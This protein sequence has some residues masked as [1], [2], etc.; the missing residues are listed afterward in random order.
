MNRP[1]MTYK[2]IF[3]LLSILLILA[4]APRKEKV[5]LNIDTPYNY[6]WDSIKWDS[7]AKNVEF[8]EI[9]DRNKYSKRINYPVIRIGQSGEYLVNRDFLLPVIDYKENI[10]NVELKD[11]GKYKLL[12]LQEIELPFKGLTV[13]NMTFDNGSYPL[14]ESAYLSI[15]G[16]LSDRTKKCVLSSFHLKTF[17]TEW[18][19][20]TGDIMLNRGV[21]KLLF[22]K[23]IESVFTDTLEFINNNSLMIGNLEGSVTNRGTK[24]NK[25]FTFRF[26]NR[27][28][29]YLKE[30][31]FNYLSISNNHTYDYGE[32]GFIDTINSLNSSLIGFSGAGKT[33]EAAS[34]YFEKDN[35]RVLSVAS[36]PNEKNGYD[37]FKESMVNDKR[38]GILFNSLIT[39]EAIKR[40]CSDK[41]FDILYVHGGDEW[42][43]EPSKE[44]VTLYQ[45]YIDLGVDLVLGSHPHVLQ[46]F[47][48]YKN[49]FIVYSLGNFI[50]PL[51]KGW[52]TG[53]ESI[54]LKLGIVDNKIIYNRVI[55]VNIDN[56]V[57][58]VDKTGRI[59]DRFYSLVQNRKD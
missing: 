4:C 9:K 22:E 31:G 42:S 43:S 1:C 7:M 36:F 3:L 28:L 47:E 10:D 58:S 8:I 26:D 57:I 50:F 16:N 25:S 41:T 59:R 14:V 46:K 54:I 39:N 30:A 48:V 17:K 6:I 53:E 13:D 38:P 44:Q 29:K 21:D 35:F 23:G 12:K 40:M 11:I 32:V 24:H 18:I 20:A 27:V 56:K 15:N 49:G 45:S 55:P 52:Y 2:T 51:M 37:G 5:F 19:A 34:K 33:V